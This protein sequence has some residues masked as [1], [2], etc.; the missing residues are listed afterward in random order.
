M[1]VLDDAKT[2]D[3][4]RLDEMMTGTID[5]LKDTLKPFAF[6]SVTQEAISS[7]SASSSIDLQLQ[8]YLKVEEK[9]VQNKQMRVNL[10]MLLEF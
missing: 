10:E 9:L 7:E 2:F 4:L 8:T 5:S 1:T 6:D 3:V